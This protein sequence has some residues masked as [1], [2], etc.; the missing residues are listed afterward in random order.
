MLTDQLGSAHGSE[1]P[2][3]SDSPLAIVSIY[4]FR[5]RSETIAMVDERNISL[6][7]VDYMFCRYI[8]TRRVERTTSRGFF[9]ASWSLWGRGFQGSIHLQC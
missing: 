3:D 9:P 7:E 1:L 4:D 8:E 2:Y 6:R 5:D